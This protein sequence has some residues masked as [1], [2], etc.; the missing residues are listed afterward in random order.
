MAKT[1]K[2]TAVIRASYMAS[3][4]V[5]ISVDPS[6]GVPASLDETTRSVEVIASTEAPAMVM[7]WDRWEVVRE[8][9]LMSGCR[10]PA[11]GQLVLLD[12]HSRE[13][14]NR[15][16][17]SF[18]SARVT[19]TEHGP[20][21][22]GRTHY[23]TVK[24]ADDAYTK[25]KEGHVTDVSIGYEVLAHIWVKDGE[26]VSMDGKTFDGP[27][28]IGVEWVPRELS[29]CPIGA[30]ENAKFRNQQPPAPAAGHNK[31]KAMAKTKAAGGKQ[32]A[33]PKSGETKRA[34]MLA[35]LRSVLVA[36]GLR[37]EEEETPE[38]ERQ[39]VELVDENGNPI[40]P[41]ELTEDELITVVEG[42]EE[43]LAEAEEE[44]AA[45]EEGTPPSDD[46]QRK[47]PVQ[48]GKQSK[49]G[50]VRNLS[51][52]QAARAE[53]SRVLAIQNMARAHGVPE[54][55]ASQLIESGAS[56]TAA[57]ARVFD[58]R[59]AT[60]TTGPGFRVTMG[61]TEQEKFRA[62][63]QD[64]LSLRCGVRV[65]RPAEG[66]TELQSYSLR[67]MAREMLVRSGQRPEG[68]IVQIVGRALATTDLPHL[69]VETSRRTLME[70]FEAAEETWRT[71]A[72]TG[73]ATDF[74]KSTAVGLEGDVKP[75]L[76]PEGGEYKE[77]NLG[78]NAEEYVVKTFGRKMVVTR[79]AIIN[80]DLNALTALPRMYGEAT[81]EMVGDVA[82]KALLDMPNTMG[83]GNPLFSA[84]HN[85]L[86][87]GKGGIPTV[88]NLGSVVTGMK[89]QKDSFGKTITIQPKFFLAPV[90]LEVPS[91]QFFNT[92]LQGAGAILGIQSK[93][94]V[95]N[96][97]GGNFFTRVYDRRMDVS[98]PNTY[99]LAG[100]RGTVVVF[101]LGGVE[102]PYIDEQI[103]FDTDGVES[104][105]RMDV[106]AKAMR[107]V[108]LAKAPGA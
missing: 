70:A 87:A 80:D 89:L 3:R 18:R 45:Q 56:L 19:A 31:E 102:S 48:Q 43:V 92:Q 64:A 38:E 23:S 62:A 8:V 54:E 81:A 9:L 39:D 51:P 95:N 40:E 32:T 53:R 88:E 101:F 71:W 28:R 25:V 69:L 5:P 16:L 63:A 17:G 36:L 75:L 14:V 33:A 2:K 67:E 46:E 44:L 99:Y 52:T 96:P 65:E 30:D 27:M 76:K 100:A 73:I 98:S 24:E 91:E 90:A 68:H 29:L 103:N 86:Y 82:Y 22:V 104:K 34:G 78:E 83:D 107:W 94:L 74:K 85:N 84:A 41:A 4:A 59:N 105:V 15:V 55:T 12:T 47:A 60:P 13:S 42:L 61:N 72:G 20:S 97:Y 37:A 10:I 77:G 108:T 106:G 79:E 11:S 93:P 26:S 21:L 50:S 35:R 1:V 49:R 6:T 57:K 66:A 7:D 58:M